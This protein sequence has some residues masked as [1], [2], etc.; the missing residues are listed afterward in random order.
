M[1]L[2]LHSVK[3][4]WAITIFECRIFSFVVKLFGNLRGEVS[5]RVS[6][7]QVGIENIILCDKTSAPLHCIWE[8][9]AIVCYAFMEFPSEKNNKKHQTHFGK[10]TKILQWS[11][12]QMPNRVHLFIKRVAKVVGIEVA[13]DDGRTNSEVEEG[14]RDKSLTSRSRK[15]TTEPALKWRKEEET[16]HR[17]QG[18]E[19]RRQNQLWSGGRRRRQIVDAE[20]TK[21][22]G[23]ISSEVEEGG[24]D[25]SSASRSRKTT[26]EPTLKWRKEEETSH[27][28][29]GRGRRQQN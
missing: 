11:C 9:F 27:R 15:M 8:G 20:V 4:S 5:T 22:D 16:S 1:M 12:E 7:N 23:R 24:G 21:D 14:G 2:S 10:T 6:T 26:A 17:H 19:R 18:R 28:H 29:Q 3:P 25:K 13:K